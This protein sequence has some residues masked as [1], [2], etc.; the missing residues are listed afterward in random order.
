VSIQNRG[1]LKLETL[2]F[3]CIFVAKFGA[4]KDAPDS[5]IQLTT[6]RDF[7]TCADRTTGQIDYDTITTF[8]TGMG[9]RCRLVL[10]SRPFARRLGA[11]PSSQG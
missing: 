7:L 9:C 3:W 5:G 6:K 8:W 10:R 11:N 4:R 1:L 2:G